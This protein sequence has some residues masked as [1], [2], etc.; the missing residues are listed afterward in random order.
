MIGK[1]KEFGVVYTPVWIV[2]LI[3]DNTMRDYQPAM[4]VCDPSCGDGAFLTRLVERICDSVPARDCR[5][6]LENI[7]GMDIDGEALAQCRDRLDETLASKGKRLKIKWDLRC[8]DS[9]NRAELT[10]YENRFDYV[11]GNPPY[12]R[13]QHLGKERRERLQADWS[14]AQHGSTDLYIAFFEIG[15]FLL[16]RGGWLGYITPNTYTKT[17]AGQL[18]RRFILGQ[19]GI[20]CLIDFGEHQVF[21]L[22]TTYSLITVLNK[23][24][25]RRKYELYRFDGDA[26][27]SNGLVSVSRLPLKGIWTLESEETMQQI[28]NLRT[29]GWP[30]GEIADIHVGIQTLADNVFILEKKSEREGYVVAI[31]KLGGEVRLESG[32]TRAILKASVMQNGYDRKERIIIFPYDNEKL[33][34]ESHLQNQYPCAYQYLKKHKNDLLKRDKGK[35]DPNRWYAFGREFGLTTTFGD[36]LITS[37]MNKRPNF[38]K[39]PSAEYTFYAGYC[40]KPKRH[41]DT[42]ELLSVLNSEEMDFYIRHT[43]RDYQNGWKSY[44]KSFIQNF[45]I[46]SHIVN[47]L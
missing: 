38:Q 1:T 31:D 12:V 29:R 41:V 40:V 26:I 47:V 5:R 37:G 36:K 11:V 21:K 18:L 4:K 22:A 46:P 13:I 2:D 35:H 7:T 45:G 24:T 39:C 17:A 44:A 30:L 33:V 32:I 10:A 8:M 34:K 3:L 25:K 28:E 16:K 14:L 43:S 27:T 9:A 15:M 6:A 19:H 42:D 20:A 23:N